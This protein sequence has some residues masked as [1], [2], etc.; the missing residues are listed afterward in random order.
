MKI[1]STIFF[2]LLALGLT[3]RILFNSKE[4]FFEALRYWFTPD[5]I[6][7]FKSE[8]TEDTWNEMKIA[9]WIGFGALGAYGGHQLFAN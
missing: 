3:F 9:L 6:S 1:A 7:A 2:G 5:I 4:D 8:W